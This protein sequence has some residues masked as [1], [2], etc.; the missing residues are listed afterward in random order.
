MYITILL[1][2][3]ANPMQ[4]NLE[5]LDHNDFHIRSQAEQNI[6]EYSKKNNIKPLLH[7]E[8]WKSNSEEKKLNIK[9]ILTTINVQDLWNPTIVENKETMLIQALKELEKY[10]INFVIEPEHYVGLAVEPS[11]GPF[12]QIV[13]SWL[14]PNNISIHP[15][16]YRNAGTFT[17]TQPNEN[18]LKPHP[19]SIA[20]SGPF[21]LAVNSWQRNLFEKFIYEDSTKDT[22]QKSDKFELSLHLYIEPNRIVT[23]IH[24]LQVLECKSKNQHTKKLNQQKPQTSP[25][26]SRQLVTVNIPAIHD[27]EIE[28]LKIVAEIEV[29]GFFKELKVNVEKFSSEEITLYGNDITL[30]CQVLGEFL[31]VKFLPENLQVGDPEDCRFGFYTHSGD[32]SYADHNLYNNEIKFHLK[33]NYAQLFIEYPSVKD[34]KIVEFEFNDLPLKVKK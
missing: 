30:K 32:K 27:D 5:K 7:K 25:F 33:P 19:N 31:S 10:K 34:T 3:L 24:S 9:R 21:K 15:Y 8:L 1:L 23:E 11:K 17:L 13:D 14:Y 4:E 18:F 20:Y 28:K 22:H 6:L 26:I 29:A 12:W 2:A 16:A